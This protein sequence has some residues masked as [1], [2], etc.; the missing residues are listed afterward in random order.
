MAV[1]RMALETVLAEARLRER[2]GAYTRPF[3][4]KGMVDEASL[5]R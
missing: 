3:R 4:D 1:V 5:T 2:F